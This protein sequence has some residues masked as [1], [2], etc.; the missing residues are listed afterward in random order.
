MS[1]TTDRHAADRQAVDHQA[2]VIDSGIGNLGN[3]ARALR[4]VGA[5]CTI[6]RDPDVVSAGRCLVLPGVGAFKPPRET[7]RGA[8]EEAIHTALDNGAWLLG[9]CVGYQ[10]LFDASTEFGTTDGLGL[11][12]GTVDHL[13]E[14]VSLPHIGWNPLV[15]VADHPLL[16]HIDPGAHMYF[17]HSFAP[18]E[19]GDGVALARA[20]HGASFVAVAGRGRVFGTQFHPEKS[21]QHGLQLLRNFLEMAN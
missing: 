19:V 5:E 11:L 7:V 8:L 18:L 12:P 14:G 21:G 13:P 4:H 6:T 10:L 17:V 9:I 15:D 16:R 20:R 3:L 1:S 2:V